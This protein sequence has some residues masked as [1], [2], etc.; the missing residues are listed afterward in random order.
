MA[1]H[2]A[3]VSRHWCIVKRIGKICFVNSEDQLVVGTFSRFEFALES[4]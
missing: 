3:H 2:S 1:L 4:F